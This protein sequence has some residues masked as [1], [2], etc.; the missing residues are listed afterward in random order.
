MNNSIRNILEGLEKLTAHDLSSSQEPATELSLLEKTLLKDWQEYQLFEAPAQ[1]MGA[2]AP[3]Q[4]VDPRTVTTINR[5]K[6]I[7]KDP[8]IVPTVAAQG[9][10]KQTAGQI[11]SSVEKKQMAL[12]GNSLGSAAT[13]ALLSPKQSAQTLTTLSNAARAREQAQKEQEK[14]ARQQ[15]QQQQQTR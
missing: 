11:P 7:T 10:A 15:Q 13:A 6:T 12:L 9:I 5:L 2:A 8:R 1:P 14:L 3:G 4:K